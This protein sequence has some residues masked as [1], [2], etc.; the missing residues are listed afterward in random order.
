MN[1]AG[2]IQVSSLSTASRIKRRFDAVLTIEDPD[3]RH[4]LRFHNRPHPDQLVLKFEDVDTQ[5]PGIALPHAIH[6]EAALDF[7]REHE[8]GSL[9]V[10]CKAG[11]ARS[12]AIALAIIADRF[13]MGKE[14]DSV[15]ALLAIRPPAI[16]NLLVLGLADYILGRNGRLAE[17]WMEVENSDKEYAAVRKLKKETV[18][19]NPSLYSRERDLQSTIARFRPDS[20]V[21]DQKAGFA[22]AAQ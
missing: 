21:A 12:S 10:H 2:S 4:P 17:A 13:G 8:S 5:V 1:R 15:A 9:L 18:E 22:V 19:R 7:A 16:P 14:K 6:V 3:I 20:L 11:I